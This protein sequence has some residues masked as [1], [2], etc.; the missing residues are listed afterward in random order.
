MIPRIQVRS[1]RRRQRVPRKRATIGMGSR[2]RKERSK[3]GESRKPDVGDARSGGCRLHDDSAKGRSAAATNA[4]N[5]T[6][7]RESRGVALPLR[8]AITP[9]MSTIDPSRRSLRRESRAAGLTRRHEEGPPPPYEGEVVVRKLVGFKT[10]VPVD[11]VPIPA[12]QRLDVQDVVCFIGR[13]PL[14]APRC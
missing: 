11:P 5:R 14:S 8:I 7:C 4:A 3:A 12:H 1:S 6:K 13:L 10:R 9:D 2:S